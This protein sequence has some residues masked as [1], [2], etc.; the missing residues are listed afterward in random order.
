MYRDARLDEYQRLADDPSQNH[1]LTSDDLDEILEKPLN[2]LPPVGESEVL[3]VRSLRWLRRNARTDED[4]DYANHCYHTTLID[5][6]RKYIAT[7]GQ[8]YY[9]KLS[10]DLMDQYDL[11]DDR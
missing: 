6:W 1:Q 10:D 7:T 4:K 11:L 8:T 3:D 9:P 5:L 2:K